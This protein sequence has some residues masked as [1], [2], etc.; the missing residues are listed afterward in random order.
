MK[1]PE[2]LR[3]LRFVRVRFKGKKPFENA[4]QHNPYTYDEIQ[5]YFPRE[6]YGVLC[7]A[8]IRALDDDTPEEL[9][10]ELYHKNFPETMEVR[11]HIYFRFDNLHENKIVLKHPYLLFPN[12]KG[13]MDSHMGELQGKGTQVVGAGSTHPSGELYE[14]KKDLPIATISYDKFIKVFGEFMNIK[15]AKVVRD[16]VSSLWKGDNITNIPIGNIISFNGLKDMGGGCFQG[17][18]PKHGSDNGM[19]FRVDTGKNT[20][21][22]FRCCCGGGSSELS[23]V[24]ND[25]MGCDDA[26][27]SCYSQD[28]ARQ[29]FCRRTEES[30]ALRCRNDM[31]HH[32]RAEAARHRIF[33]VLLRPLNCLRFSYCRLTFLPMH[34]RRSSCWRRSY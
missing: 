28:Q 22:C 4:W 2:Q 3:N 17:S 9:L 24:M 32:R 25:V 15:K 10:K 11:G 14:L 1:I 16:H 20:W 12:S 34:H 23:G 33:S 26:G 21:Y 7:G 6:N 19:N 31:F 30:R 18:H 8:D 13:E 5:Q 29:V 27:S